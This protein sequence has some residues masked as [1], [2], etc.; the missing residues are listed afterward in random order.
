MTAKVT[1]TAF[2]SRF[3]AAIF[4]IGKILRFAFFLMFLLILGSKTHRVA[5]YSIF[6]IIFV[7][8]T[9]NIVDTTSQFFLRE[10]YRFRYYVVSGEFDYFLTKPLSPLIRSLFGGSDILDLPILLLSVVFIVYSASQIGNI[11]SPF[12]FL[13]IALLINALAIALAMHILV[14][15]IGVMTTEIDHTIM[16][17]RDITQMGRLPVDIYR[18]PLSW[19]LTFII[20]VGIMITIPAKSFFGI[21][22]PQLVVLSLFISAIFL[23]ASIRFWHFALKNYTSVSS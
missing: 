16:I 13:Y 1:Q 9:F 14:L 6:Q 17:Y 2:V 18:E 8:A 22:S 23:I 20:P 10:V 12:V 11:S 21:L 5:D 15:G 7:F 19:I 4:I 3:G